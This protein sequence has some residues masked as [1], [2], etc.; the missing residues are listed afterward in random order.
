MPQT[1]AR[2]KPHFTNQLH[3]SAELAHLPRNRQMGRPPALAGRERR[4]PDSSN[5]LSAF[6][7]PA[8]AGFPFAAFRLRHNFRAVT[9]LAHH[10]ARKGVHS[11]PMAHRHISAQSGG[12]HWSRGLS[13]SS[14]ITLCV[15]LSK[16]LRRIAYPVE[17]FGFECVPGELPPPLLEGNGD[18]MGKQPGLFEKASRCLANE[19]Q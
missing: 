15:S 9:H 12:R 1:R 13:C 14:T 19:L 5:C 3:L 16:V 18:R 7:S 11:R 10:V 8:P 4:Q 2:R 17:P 6:A